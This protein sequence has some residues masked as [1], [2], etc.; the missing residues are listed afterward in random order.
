MLRLGLLPLLILLPLFQPLDAMS[1]KAAIESIGAHTNMMPRQRGVTLPMIRV[2]HDKVVLYRVFYLKVPRPGLPTAISY[3]TY[4]ASYDLSS[5][6]FIALRKFDAKVKLAGEEPWAVQFHKFD[7]PTDIIAEF[8]RIWE[9]YDALIPPFLEQGKREP[10]PAEKAKA[11]EYMGY[12]ARHA[13]PPLRPVYDHY[14]GDFL[15]FVT[16]LAR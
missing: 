14:G 12:F 11:K 7:K 5:N 10:T 6:Q 13:E 15:S 2:E 1:V 8:N 16:K 9:C 3:P 4:V